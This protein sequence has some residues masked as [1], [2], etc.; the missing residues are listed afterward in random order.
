MIVRIQPPAGNSEETTRVARLIMEAAGDRSQEVVTVTD[1]PS[2]GFLV[3]EEIFKKL[4]LNADTEVTNDK[5]EKI[6]DDS[7]SKKKS[8][9][10]GN[11]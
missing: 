6:D 8:S 11:A 3:P 9:K 5:G 10:K 4:D 7:D 2:V 1:G